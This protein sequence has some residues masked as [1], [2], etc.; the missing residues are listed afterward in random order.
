MTDEWQEIDYDLQDVLGLASGEC[1]PIAC[2]EGDYHTFK[3]ANSSYRDK[4]DSIPMSS[5]ENDIIPVVWRPSSDSVTI[6]V[7]KNAVE[8]AV[9]NKLRLTLRATKGNSPDSLTECLFVPT[10]IDIKLSPNSLYSVRFYGY[11]F[12]K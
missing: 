5:V 3:V 1:L 8:E 9:E 10:S 11:L 2:P 4:D 6:W 7:D 12:E